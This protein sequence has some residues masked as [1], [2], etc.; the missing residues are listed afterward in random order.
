MSACV[1]VVNTSA[2]A[3]T[4][5]QVV[6]THL[7]ANRLTMIGDPRDVYTNIPPGEALEN[8]CRIFEA[9]TPLYSDDPPAWTIGP[10][11]MVLTIVVGFVDKKVPIAATISEVNFAGAPSWHAAKGPYGLVAM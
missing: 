8:S 3:I 10:D 6:F 4:H 1:D 5:F 9:E 11:T 7:A 2:H